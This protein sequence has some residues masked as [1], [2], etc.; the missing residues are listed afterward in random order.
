[1]YDRHENLDFILSAKQDKD[2]YNGSDGNDNLLR[3]KRKQNYI[4]G[5]TTANYSAFDATRLNMESTTNI[6]RSKHNCV[7]VGSV[8]IL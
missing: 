7:M 2:T 8:C 4:D 3:T 6:T 5:K 1:M